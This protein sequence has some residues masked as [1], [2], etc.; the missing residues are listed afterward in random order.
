MPRTLLDESH[1]HP[2]VRDAVSHLHAEVVHNVHAA[3]QSNSVLVVGMASNPFV[4][5]ARKAPAITGVSP[6]YVLDG[7]SSRFDI[8]PKKSLKPGG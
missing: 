8:Y 2:A 6:G 3:S 4:K 7:K 5:R 1:V